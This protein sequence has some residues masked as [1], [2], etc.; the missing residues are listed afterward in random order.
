MNGI[1][2]RFGP[3]PGNRLMCMGLPDH[4]AVAG[5]TKV[6]TIEGGVFVADSVEARLFPASDVVAVAVGEGRCVFTSRVTDGFR[7]HRVGSGQRAIE[8]DYRGRSI[9]VGLDV[10]VVDS[11]R[12]RL[13]YR[14]ADNTPFSLPVGAR[15]SWPKPFSAGTGAIWLDGQRVFRVRDQGGPKS[16]GRLPTPALRWMTGPR[17]SALFETEGGVWAL[18]ARGGMVSL[19]DLDFD[20]CR[21]CPEGARLLAQSEQ[22]L[23]EL[24]LVDGSVRNRKASFLYP[25]GFD[26]DP[27]VVDEE[28]GLLRT[29]DGRVVAEGCLPSAVAASESIVFGPGGTAWGRASGEKLWS[30]APLC[31]EHLGAYDGGVIQVGQRI[32]GFDAEGNLLFDLPL[33][34]DP[35]LDGEVDD[36]RVLEGLMHFLVNDGWVTVDFSGRRVGTSLPNVVGPTA[37]DQTE[38]WSHDPTTRHLLGPTSGFPVPVDGFVTVDDGRLFVWTEDGMGLL[39]EPGSQR[40]MPTS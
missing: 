3:G 11:G 20:S 39:F 19:G 22:G 36:F 34:L 26:P 32:E 5:S 31:G 37:F 2:F 27:V 40:P 24:N 6:W 16:A 1:S 33:P 21:I 17:G 9:E 35:E 25:A 8:C 23:V 4:I 14:L 29:L 7:L 10:V 18:S 12:D 38:E 28:G 13:A 30:H 15:D